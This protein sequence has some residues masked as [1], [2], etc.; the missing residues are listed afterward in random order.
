MDPL[1]FS[2]KNTLRSALFVIQLFFL[3]SFI[4]CIAL[5]KRDY[6]VN[7]FLISPPKHTEA[8]LMCTHNIYFD[9]VT[10]KYQQFLVNKKLN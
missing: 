8:F 3:D 4:T 2:Y 9:G 5:D 1:L 7:N 6:K 10:G